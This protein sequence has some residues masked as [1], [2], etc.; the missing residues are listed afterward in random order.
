MPEQ[1]DNEQGKAPQAATAQEDPEAQTTADWPE[2]APTDFAH[3]AWMLVIILGVVILAWLI[4]VLS[5]LDAEKEQASS[6]ASRQEVEQAGLAPESEATTLPRAASVVPVRAIGS[7]K[8]FITASPPQRLPEGAAMVRLGRLFDVTQR[9]EG[10]S[11]E[12]LVR[13]PGR[14]ADQR[15]FATIE[16]TEPDA[17]LLAGDASGMAPDERVVVVRGSTRDYAFPVA[18]L[19]LVAAVRF[20]LEGRSLLLSWSQ[21]SQL[22]RAYV[23]IADDETALRDS[24]LLYRA[25][26]V[27]YDES[28]GS[29]W[30]PLSRRC[31]AGERANETLG[32]MP[33]QVW[34]WGE[35]SRSHPESVVLSLGRG[36]ERR[37]ETASALQEDTERYLADPAIPVPLRSFQARS[38]PLPAKEL[39]L[40]MH[41][42][43]RARA[44][45]LASLARTGTRSVRDK[46]QGQ[47]V[48]VTITSPRTAHATV[49]GEPADA[50]VMLWFSWAE[51]FPNTDVYAM[52]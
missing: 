24:G 8:L 49:A 20:R 23:H 48:V 41:I 46:L 45:P 52:Q 9:A 15:P 43:D 35:W 47:E 26:A 31:I 40:G 19:R 36:S 16:D 10:F 12:E 6:S 5:E 18:A 14:W 50:P 29:L 27:L 38:S 13:M 11:L 22:A 21:L 3:H 32:G 44:Y 2:A 34:T 37:E 33:V 39:V 30:D 17:W 25:C 51:A 1:D 7:D 4:N 42:G 28:S